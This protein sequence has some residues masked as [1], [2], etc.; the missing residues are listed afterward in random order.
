MVR[1]SL[2]GASVL[3]VGVAAVAL[4]ATASA[5]IAGGFAVR[6]QSASLMGSAFAGAAAGVDLSSAFWNPAA[7]G[8]A[9]NGLTTQSSYTAIFANTELSNVTVNGGPFG[10]ADATDIDKI[11]VLSG[12]YA[13][14]RLN[15]KIVLGISNNAPFGLATEA[16]DQ[17]FDG[18]LHGRAASM[19]TI[20]IAPTLAYE[21]APGVQVAAGIQLEYMKLKLWSAAGLAPT[22]PSVSIKL[23]DNIGVGY[24]AG[25]LVK[26]GDRSNIGLGFRSKVSHDLEG[27][28]NTP[29][30]SSPASAELETPE[31]ATLSFV[32]ALSSQMRAMGTVEWTN[33]SRLQKVPVVGV[34]NAVLD[35][36]WDDGW[37]IS[38]GL[39]YDY[40]PVITLRGG[41]AYEK[42]PIQEASQRLSVLPDSDRVWLTMGGSYRY[43]EATTIDFS[44]AHIFFEDSHLTRDTLVPTGLILDADVEN[45]A[46]IIS[47][48]MRTKW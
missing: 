37:F 44:Y 20:N 48:G 10:G 19:M 39:E 31:I 23:D 7:F 2:T 24:T 32:Q 18:R 36:Q 47:V 21:I 12:S 35:A 29:V 17:G 43:S 28:F 41:V 33:W 4:A 27:D 13:A 45:S 3:R 16:D 14:Y 34:P 25:I 9:E 8:I 42:S 1:F 46:N 30:G 40:S 6:E 38:G 22:A 15:D 26:T 5:T 11:G